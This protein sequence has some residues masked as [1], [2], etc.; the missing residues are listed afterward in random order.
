MTVVQPGALPIWLKNVDLPLRA[1]PIPGLAGVSG[2]GQAALADLIG[3]LIRPA[4]GT[5]HV[6]GAAPRGWSP[7]AAISAGI[8]RIPEDRHKTGTIAD[9]DLTENAVLELYSRSGFSR[10]GWMNWRAAREFAAKIIQGSAFACCRPIADE[11][12]F[13]GR[14][15]ARRTLG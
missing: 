7:H 1:G 3:G 9:F 2:N 11:C 12:G 15:S 6:K 4:S 5:F 8:A 14:G 13:R 10:Y